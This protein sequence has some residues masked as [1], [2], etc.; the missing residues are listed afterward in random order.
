MALTI[1]KAGLWKRISAWLFD[2]ILAACITMGFA[3]VI[4]GILGYDAKSDELVSYYAK[5]EQEYG[6][7]FNITQEEFDTK[8]KELLGL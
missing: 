2:F 8:K 7:D 3:F 1:Q 4:S 6:V 5:Y